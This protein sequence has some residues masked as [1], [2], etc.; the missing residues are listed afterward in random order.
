MKRVF[1]LEIPTISEIYDYIVDLADKILEKKAYYDLILAV[2]RGGLIPARILGDLLKISDI[3]VIYSRYYRSPYETLEKPVIEA[4]DIGGIRGKS[5]LVVD[6]VADTG[7]TLNEIKKYLISNGAKNVDIAVIYIKPWNKAKV[8]YFSRETDAWIIFP[9]E[10][11]ETCIQLIREGKKEILL[12]ELSKKPE[13]LKIF[14]K[15][16]SI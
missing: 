14:E 10:F 6:D 4:K 7:D 13:M 15:F 5:I 3:R 16:V 12:N 8:N 11:V 9:W 1:K 2:A